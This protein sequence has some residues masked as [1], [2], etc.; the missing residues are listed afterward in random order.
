MN[1][2]GLTLLRCLGTRGDSE[3]QAL[4]SLGERQRKQYSQPDRFESPRHFLHQ[5]W[6]VVP[7]G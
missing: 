4:E 7:S 1:D 5:L 6:L 2:L 3:L